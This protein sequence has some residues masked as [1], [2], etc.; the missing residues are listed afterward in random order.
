MT[1]TS[2]ARRWALV[3]GAA[4]GIG[5]AIAGGLAKAGAN[6]ILLD[7]PDSPRLAGAVDAVRELGVETHAV[8]GDLQDVEACRRLAEEA[9]SL[10]GRLDILVLNASMEI[11]Q[12]WRMVPVA[13]M[14]EQW[15]VNLPSSLV[16]LQ[17][18]VPPMVERGYGRVLS[19]G[20]IQERK[21]NPDRMAYAAL[22]AAQANVIL[23]LARKHGAQG[24]TFNIL[25]PGAIATPPRSPTRLTGSGSRRR[26]LR[27]VSASPRTVSPQRC[28][29]ARSRVI[30][31]RGDHSGGRRLVSLSHC[32]TFP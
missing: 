32:P 16:L 29:F 23:S 22:K 30:P 20:S 7:R 24:V 1:E 19:I 10:A 14:D 31:Q 2:P 6:V 5:R 4:Q 8:R 15:A 28:C 25:A 27:A 13:D 26:F 21:P 17:L 9:L 18:L 12:D 3:T 11:R